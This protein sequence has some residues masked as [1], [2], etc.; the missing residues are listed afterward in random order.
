MEKLLRSKLN[1]FDR[2]PASFELP[3]FDMGFCPHFSAPV[4]PA[5]PRPAPA[6]PNRITNHRAPRTPPPQYIYGIDDGMNEAFKLVRG[7][8]CCLQQAGLEADELR[9]DVLRDLGR[10]AALQ[11]L[12]LLD[13]EE[14][15]EASIVAA[16]VYLHRAHDE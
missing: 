16:I 9:R 13:D 11:N 7:K 8:V 4:S 6:T 1:S 3:S 12:E 15:R 5:S 2:L 10:F 14:E